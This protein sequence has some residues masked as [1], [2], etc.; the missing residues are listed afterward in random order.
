MVFTIYMQ[1]KTYIYNTK[2]WLNCIWPPSQNSLYVII[3]VKIH[4]IK[5]LLASHVIE[6]DNKLSSTFNNFWIVHNKV[7]F[8]GDI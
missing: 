2:N 7:K 3:Y 5:K 6:S 1:L 4:F 8:T